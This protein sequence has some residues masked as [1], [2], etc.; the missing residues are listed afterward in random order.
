MPLSAHMLALRT[1]ISLDYFSVTKTVFLSFSPKSVS[2][3]VLG[4][5][6]YIIVLAEEAYNTCESG[7]PKAVAICLD[8]YCRD[9]GSSIMAFL[10]VISLEP[11]SFN[12]LAL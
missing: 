5:A 9:D 8:S 10:S 2:P 1:F 4:N 11:T 6:R 7:S 12:K 3:V